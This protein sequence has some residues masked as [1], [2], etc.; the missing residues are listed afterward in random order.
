MTVL[1]SDINSIYKY[2]QDG[3]EVDP[4][5][6]LVHSTL[7]LKMQKKSLQIIKALTDEH[8]INEATSTFLQ[9][10]KPVKEEHILANQ[11]CNY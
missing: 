7:D 9:V 2:L 1:E 3:H 5:R 11:R 6:I 4:D 10:T 8:F